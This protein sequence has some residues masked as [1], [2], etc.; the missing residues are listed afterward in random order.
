MPSATQNAPKSMYR[1]KEGLG[2]WEHRGKV[3]AVGIGASPAARR[4]DENPETSIGAWVILSIR[5]ALEDAGVSPDQVDGIVMDPHATTGDVWEGPIPESFA[6]AFQLTDSPLDGISSLSTEFIL[7]NMP[8]LKNVNFSMYGPGCM[9]NA[10]NV[11]SQAIGD[12]L[13]HTCLVVKAWNNNAGRY[14]HGG[15]QAVDTVGGAAAFKMP[16]GLRG[17]IE[18]IAFTFDQYC[19]RYGKSHD[20]LAP[21][22]VNQRRNGLMNPDGFYTQ[23]RPEVLTIEDYLGARWI[24]KPMNIFDCDMPIQ[25]AVAYLFTT[26]ERAKDTKQKPVYILNHVANHPK[27]RST[28]ETIDEVE[29]SQASLARKI[30]EGSGVTANDVDVLNP[31]DGFLQFTGYY[32]EGLG[33]RGVKKGE[34]LDFYAG[35]ISVEG[36]NPFSSSGGNN[37]SGRTRWWM[38]TDSIQQLQGRAGQ[39]QVRIKNG[40]PEVAISGGPMPMGG[41]WTVWG[42]SPD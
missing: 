37:G 26:A 16:W 28:L 15:A 38:H 29:A 21:F 8:E 14:G 39:R 17:G 3:A 1:D 4:W 30:Y 27:V 19:R 2:V 33:W 18:E 20:G 5:K 22:A 32:L 25:V 12:G 23:N 40:Q 41:N 11:V 35:D 34:A 6:K 31:Y 10:L 13:T 36:P 24:A 42:T 7:K 9:S